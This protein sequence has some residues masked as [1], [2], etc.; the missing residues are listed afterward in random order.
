MNMA[1]LLPQVNQLRNKF[2]H[3]PG[4]DSTIEHFELISDEIEI[5]IYPQSVSK[6]FMVMV[7]SNTQFKQIGESHATLTS[8]MLAAVA[9]AGEHA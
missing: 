7:W 5:L 3:I 4:D 9:Y 6:D 8:A 1:T 2:E